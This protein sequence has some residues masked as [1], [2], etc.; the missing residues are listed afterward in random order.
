[1]QDDSEQLY[2]KHIPVKKPPPTTAAA[3]ARP[4]SAR[5]R[6]LR[7]LG[8]LG[9]LVVVAAGRAA[10]L[11]NTPSE[12]TA[13]LRKSP[14]AENNQDDHQ[15]DNQFRQ[16]DTTWHC[17]LLSAFPNLLAGRDYTTLHSGDQLAPR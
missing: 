2:L 16:T 13:D 4:R 14:N 1:Y 17:C 8:G 12:R 9:S 15:N 7:A 11:S 5:I 3:H 6:R 10:E